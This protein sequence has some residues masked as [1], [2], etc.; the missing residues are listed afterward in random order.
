MNEQTIYREQYEASGA[1]N[2]EI[3]AEAYD[4]F[5]GADINSLELDEGFRLLGQGIGQGLG[6]YFKQAALPAVSALMVVLLCGMAETMF[7]ERERTM[8]VLPLVGTLAITAAV[9]GDLFA[10]VGSGRSA[11]ET[12]STFS[13]SLL[14][15]LA[16]TGAAV[17]APGGASARYLAAIV[18][19]DALI[20]VIDRVLIPALMAYVLVCVADAAIGGDTLGV[21][22]KF[23]K[24]AVVTV[25]TLIITGFT[26]YLTVSGIV[27]GGADALTI[28]ATKTVISNTV[29]VVGGAIA[30]ASETVIASTRLVKNT[31]G[32]V[33]IL[34]LAAIAVG[35]FLRLGVRYLLLKAVGAVS[36]LA[37]GGRMGKLIENL[38]G[39]FGILLGMIAASAL[40]ALIAVVAMISL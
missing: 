37:G 32:V 21:L 19:S 29:P 13:K 33:G 4:L 1:E 15:T 2:I 27:A 5:G 25:L 16:A 9:C 14:A 39:A 23:L 24:T 6:G 17:G 10:L 22:A 28:K 31:A 11:V 12:L 30:D 7:P 36:P 20:T 38:A 3:P 34:A 8:K 40:M 35:S 26:I 18:F